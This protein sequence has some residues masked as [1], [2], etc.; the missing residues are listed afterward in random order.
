MKNKNG[1]VVYYPLFDW[2]R[3]FL[4]LTV[5]FVHSGIITFEA[6]G[7]FA[8]EIFFALSGWLIGGILLKTKPSELNRFYFN[9]AIRIWIPYFVTLALIVAASILHKDVLSGKWLEFVFYKLTFVYNWFGTTQLAEFSQA[10]PLQGTGNHF[11]SV[12]IE[13]QFYLL[14]PLLLV[15]PASRFGKCVTPWI[16]L[17]V[18][19]YCSQIQGASI[20]FGVAAAVIVHKHGN[21][22]E[23]SMMKIA[24]VTVLLISGVAFFNDVYFMVVA[25]FGSL[26]MVLLLAVKG[27]QSVFGKFAGGISYE[28]YMNQWIGGVLTHVVIKYTGFGAENVYVKY[29]LGLILSLG[30]ASFL[31]WHIDR[32]FLGMRNQLYTPARG[33]AVA[34]VAYASVILGVFGG[35]I[36]AIL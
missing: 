14:A 1:V 20:F 12:N 11:W 32:R 30:V 3:F 15:L 26:A 21:I 4:A 6:V 10:M 24:L 17:S 22:H 2:L 23:E 33:K 27:K 18:M 34:I 9:R 25:P 29:A 35:M 13:E 36:F 19:A 8:V 5:L 16:V 31:Y 7:S 28:L